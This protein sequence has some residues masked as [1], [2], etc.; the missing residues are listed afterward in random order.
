MECPAFDT[1]DDTVQKVDWRGT[2]AEST[3]RSEPSHCAACS[4]VQDSMREE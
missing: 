3:E 1:L 2:L 4:V